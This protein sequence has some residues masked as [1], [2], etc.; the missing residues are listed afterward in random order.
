MLLLAVDEAGEIHERSS[1][2]IWRFVKTDGALHDAWVI[3][4]A[5]IICVLAV[6]FLPLIRRLPAGTRNRFIL[7][8]AV[9]VGSAFGMELWEGYYES[10]HGS[11][12]DARYAILVGVEETGEMLGIV[13]FIDALLRHLI[14][15]M[16]LDYLLLS[17]RHQG[18]ESGR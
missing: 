11:W 14:V 15:S 16:R 6:Y 17:S 12:L 1:F 3:P 4:Y 9:Y 7:A 10:Y 2:L 8:G 18:P 5:A 13:M